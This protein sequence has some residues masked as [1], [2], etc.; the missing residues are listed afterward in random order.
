MKTLGFN[1]RRA[2][3]SRCAFRDYYET[4]HVPLA[5]RY[6]RVFTKYVRNYVVHG[7]PQEPRYDCLGE[8]WFDG[9]DAIAGIRAWLASPEGQVLHDDEAR[10]MDRARMSSCAVGERLLFGPA[11]AVEPGMTR[12]HGLAVRRMT[13]VPPAVFEARMIGFGE[14]LVRR[15]EHSIVRATLDLAVDPPAGDLPLHALISLWPVAPDA[16]LDIP[17]IDAAIG[18]LTSLTFDAYETPPG[19]LRG[20]DS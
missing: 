3:L 12:K 17:A 1:P 15:N 7:E 19:A 14:E 11:R 5:L 8:F 2:D 6:I 20:G 10:F 13:S 9:P 18:N 4:Q 16:T